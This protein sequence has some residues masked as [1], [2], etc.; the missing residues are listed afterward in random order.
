M[1]KLGRRRFARLPVLPTYVMRE[2][3]AA[4]VIAF[5]I[6]ASLVF[7]FTIRNAH[8]HAQRFGLSFG[9]VLGFSSTLAPVML[10]LVLGLAVFAAAAMTFARLSA[11][12][13]ILAA[14]A[15]GVSLFTMA[16]PVLMIGLFCSAAALANNEWG[17]A[18]SQARFER[19]V[20]HY[21]DEALEGAFRPGARANG[22][23]AGRSGSASCSSPCSRI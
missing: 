19:L 11:D 1:S 6:C 8:R 20:A 15:A 13:E 4:F 16:R 12:N 23:W 9:D 7:F 5:G 18:W 22:V 10:S 2:F 3:G 21:Q 17:L 14:R